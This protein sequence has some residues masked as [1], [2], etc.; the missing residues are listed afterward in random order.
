MKKNFLYLASQSP[1]RAEILRRLK[2][3]F[4]IIPSDYEE[5]H[6]KNSKERPAALVLRHAKGKALLAKVPYLK[7]TRKPLVLGADTLVY[8]R[9]RILGKPASYTAA[10][11]LLMEMSGKTHEV[12]TG[13][14]LLDPGSGRVF[15]GYEK[16]RVR[17]H[18]WER[19]KIKKYVKDIDALD[20]AGSYAI[21][22]KPCIVKSFTG[23]R[24]NIVGLPQELLLKLLKKAG[25]KSA[26]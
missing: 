8:F 21:Q 17:F 12:Y 18:S 3:P 1:R 22:M 20:K 10:E 6:P 13:V 16:S 26:A 5:I 11:K 23:S 15:S 7:S 24:T 19:E 4:R 25:T 2:I 9:G 14:A